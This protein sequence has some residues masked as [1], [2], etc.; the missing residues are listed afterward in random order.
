VNPADV[1]VR[2]GLKKP[3]DANTTNAQLISRGDIQTRQAFTIT[4]KPNDAGANEG[5][6]NKNLV[7]TN[8]S[9]SEISQSTDGETMI[10]QQTT[11]KG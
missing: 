10:I 7:G 1:L 5:L 6:L 8:V 3:G 9:E 2:I 11:S 4:K